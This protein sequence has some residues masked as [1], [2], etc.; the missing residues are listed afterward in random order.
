V[1]SNKYFRFNIKNVERA[2]EDLIA[3]WAFDHGA[4]GTAEVLPFQQNPEDYSVATLSSELFHLDIFFEQ[5][6]DPELVFEFRR[7]WPL[8]PIECLAEENRDWMAEWK[9][10]FHPFEL[11]DGIWIVPSWTKPPPQSRQ[12]IWMDP[13]MAFGTGTHETTK[14]A[15]RLLGEALRSRPGARVLDVG[16]GTGILA[17]LA[18]RMGASDIIATDVDPEAVRVANENRELNHSVRTRISTDSLDSMQ[19]PFDVVVANIIDGVLVALQTDLKRLVKPGGVLILSGILDERLAGF[20]TRFLT[21]PFQIRN[22]ADMG[23]WR[24]WSLEK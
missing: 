24:A 9:K 11:M 8:F 3:L 20:R 19:E 12:V 13:G 14:L 16:T 5:A 23:E 22:E 2:Q 21:S 10:G 18:E 6:P 7:R 4:S 15:A 1:N 17:F